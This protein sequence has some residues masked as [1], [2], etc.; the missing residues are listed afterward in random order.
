[1]SNFNPKICRK[2]IDF[3][4]GFA[5]MLE[6]RRKIDPGPTRNMYRLMLRSATY[7]GMILYEDK[8]GTIVAIAC[9]S[10]GTEREEFEDRHV[11]H[12]DY[13]LMK[14][15]LQGSYYF[16]RCMDFF[17]DTISALHP[18]VK[19]VMME[20]EASSKRNNRLYSKFAQLT[21]IVQGDLDVLH[22]YQTTMDQFSTYAKN[23]L[24][25]IR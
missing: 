17:S 24:N 6:T 7:G 20:A 23:L 12:V 5:F 22:V 4:R 19:S 13:I 10:L 11:V 25:R 15:E 18:E 1:M 3:A 8:Q 16:L 9:Y 2:D 14:P 21:E